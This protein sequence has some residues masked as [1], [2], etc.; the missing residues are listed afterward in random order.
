MYGWVQTDCH[1]SASRNSVLYVCCFSSKQ[2]PNLIFWVQN[3]ILA[4]QTHLSEAS[5]SGNWV[6]SRISLNCLCRALNTRN[7]ATVAARF[8]LEQRKTLSRRFS[9][10]LIPVESLK[11]LILRNTYTHVDKKMKVLY[12]WRF[13]QRLKNGFTPLTFPLETKRQN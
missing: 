11:S 2:L 4:C 12:S 8:Q 5:G 3:R 1:K 10:L 6:T 13:K 9:R 7:Q